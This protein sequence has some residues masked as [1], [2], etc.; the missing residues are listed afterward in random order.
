MIVVTLTDCPPALRGDLSKWLIEIHTGVYVGRVSAR[1]REALW[2]RI[3]EHAKNGRATMVYPAKNE[4]R[5]IFRVHNTTW[6]PIDFD[7]L[8]LMLHPNMQRLGEKTEQ[9]TGFSKAYHIQQAR[10]MTKIQNTVYEFPERYIVLDLE[11][12]GLYPD[13]DEILEIAAVLV[14]NKQI[15][16]RFQRYIQIEGSI[17]EPVKDLTGIT[18]DILQKEGV[19]PQQALQEF[20][21]FI[22]KETI[23]SHNLGF[24]MQFLTNALE[25]EEMSRITNQGID[26][27][28]L[29]R[30][31]K[32]GLKSYQLEWLVQYF[33]LP[34]TTFHRAL[35]DAETTMHLFEKLI[36]ISE[37]QTTN[38]RK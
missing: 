20:C 18:E 32:R 22:K 24:D 17:P 26:T 13:K 30:K 8:T 14:E 16:K 7:G 5:M 27:L 25:N 28:T 3:K 19:K 33:K 1:V 35:A 15:Q 6:E 2:D 36:E 4:Q 21:A 23:I 12:T 9:K 38:A 31:I 11:T 29:T 10:R 37:Q 34:E